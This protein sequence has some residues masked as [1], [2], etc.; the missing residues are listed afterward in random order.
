LLQIF[1]NIVTIIVYWEDKIGVLIQEE[2]SSTIRTIE[3]PLFLREK[4]ENA[5]MPPIVKQEDSVE[6]AVQMV[7]APGRNPVM[8]KQKR[9]PLVAQFPQAPLVEAPI[10]EKQSNKK[11]KRKPR[12]GALP[13][14]ESAAPRVKRKPRVGKIANASQ[15]VSAIPEAAIKKSGKK[16]QVGTM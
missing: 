7:M 10:V 13:A 11:Q 5:H 14:Q 8:A 9:K 15:V 6:E 3:M 4:W 12:V 2:G 16:P 1:F